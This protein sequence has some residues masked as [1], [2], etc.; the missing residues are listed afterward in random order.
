MSLFIT[1]IDNRKIIISGTGCALADFIYNNISFTGESFRKYLSIKPGDGG[2]LPG[3]LTFTEEIENFSGCSFRKVIKDIIGD[4][5]YDAFNVGGP[6][7]VSLIHAAQL[8]GRET[9][10]LRFYGMAGNDEAGNRIFDL[11]EKTPLDIKNYRKSFAKATPFTYVLSDPDY[12]NGNGERTFINNIGTAWDY[13]PEFLDE[14]FYSSD[15]ICLGGTALVPLIHKDLS[16]ILARAKGKGSIT[17][18]NTVYDFLSEKNFPGQPWRLVD[19]IEDYR[20]IDILIMDREEALKIS[21]TSEIEDAAE[22]FTKTGV[23]SFIITNGAGSVFFRSDGRIFRD[24]DLMTLPVS[25]R[26]KQLLLQKD[27]PRGDTT[28]CG[29]NFAGGVI[30]SVAMQIR[31]NPLSQLNMIEAVSWGVASG[32]FTCFTFGGTYLEQFPEEKLEKVRLIREDYLSQIKN[33]IN[34]G[35]S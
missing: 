32:G 22:Y 20:L 17:I 8:L 11:A 24:Y 19:N 1:T 31:T 9:F 21:G 16:G 28:G 35:E 13:T 12:Y 2:L 30:A 5:Q 25:E 27:I 29:D 10:E 34:N 18:V 23:S 14:S 3:K 15:I 26:V 7:I 6:S 4:R 33:I